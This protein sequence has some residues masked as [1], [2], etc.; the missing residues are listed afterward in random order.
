VSFLIRPVLLVAGVIAA[1]FV[2]PDTPNFSVLEAFIAMFLIIVA[3]GAL[4]S[5]R[6]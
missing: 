1:V 4:A 6:R 5:L 3:I 2:A